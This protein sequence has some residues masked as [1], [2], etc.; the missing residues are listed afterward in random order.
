MASVLSSLTTAYFGG[1]NANL[2]MAYVPAEHQGPLTV[3]CNMIRQIT[4]SQTRKASI[5]PEFIV[6]IGWTHQY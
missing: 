3:D 5:F 1:K 4:G 2:T 6:S